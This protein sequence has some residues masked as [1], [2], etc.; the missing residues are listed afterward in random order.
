MLPRSRSD[1]DQRNLMGI[2]ANLFENKV[3]GLGVR[4]F[5]E[6]TAFG[7]PALREGVVG[8]RRIANCDGDIRAS[9]LTQQPVEQ[10]GASLGTPKVVVMPRISSFGLRS[11]RATANASSISSPISVSM[12]IL[13]EAFSVPDCAWQSR[14]T[15]TKLS[16]M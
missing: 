6:V 5:L 8:L 16:N 10:P 3:Y 2:T 4:R 15:M 13:S 14:A 11:A 7:V 12:I 9:H 1:G